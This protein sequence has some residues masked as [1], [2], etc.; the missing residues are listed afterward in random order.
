MPPESSVISAVRSDHSMSSN[1]QIPGVAN[2]AL[3]LRALDGV[4]GP[5]DL[6]FFDLGASAVTGGTD[7]VLM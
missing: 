2:V 6:D 3:K 4:V 7:M 1:G 5:E